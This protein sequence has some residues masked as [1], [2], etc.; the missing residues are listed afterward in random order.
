MQAELLEAIK[1]RYR[2]ATRSE[3]QRI[4]DEFISI[5]GY[6]WKHAFRRRS[7]RRCWWPSLDK[8]SAVLGLVQDELARCAPV[9]QAASWTRPARGALP[10]AGRLR[11]M[12]LLIPPR[13]AIWILDPDRRHPRPR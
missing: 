8:H 1:E 2:G 4:L 3:K 5:A 10:E 11:G 12:V 13:N 7:F 9:P 6:H